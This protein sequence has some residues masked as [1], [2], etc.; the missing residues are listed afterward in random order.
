VAAIPKGIEAA[1][2]IETKVLIRPVNVGVAAR[3]T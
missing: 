2:A 3:S 1:G